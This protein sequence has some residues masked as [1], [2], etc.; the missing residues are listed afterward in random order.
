MLYDNAAFQV[1]ERKWFGLTQKHGG[2]ASS[3]ITQSG[4]GTT[5]TPVKRWYPKGPID[6]VGFGVKCL[7]TLGRDATAGNTRAR[8]PIRMY[9]SSSNGTTK[10]TVLATTH[11]QAGS[12]TNQTRLAL[13]GVASDFSPASSEVERGRWITIFTGTPTTD[14][15]T[16]SPSGGTMLATGSYAL[17]VDYVRKYTDGEQ[18]TQ[19]WEFRRSA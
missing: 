17:F 10:T 11:I 19:S 13:Y 15:G 6:I 5:T 12:A 2:E 9:K 3:P 18:A 7:A 8:I 1:V 14:A 16:L 4:T